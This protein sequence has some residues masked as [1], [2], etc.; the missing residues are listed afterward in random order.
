MKVWKATASNL[1]EITSTLL[2]DEVVATP[3]ETAYGLLADATSTKA[4]KKIFKI[5]GRDDKK[6]PAL[7]VA[8]VK[9]AYKY[10]VFGAQAKRIVKRFWPGPLTIVVKAKGGLSPLVKQNKTVALRV[11][12]QNYLRKI[13]TLVG[14]PLTATSAN[15]TG[16]P[17]LYSSRAVQ[18]QLSSHGLKYLIAGGSIPRQDPSTIFLIKNNKIIILRPGPIKL[19]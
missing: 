2:G 16:Q 7:V 13:I 15:L 1:S 14:K 10:G 9:M 18:K 8:D 11:P 17:N 19:K 6:S 3:T 5:K 4:V 12:S